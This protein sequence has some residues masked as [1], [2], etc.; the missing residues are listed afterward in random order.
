MFFFMVLPSGSVGA[1]RQNHLNL[2]EAKDT[3]SA[4]GALRQNPQT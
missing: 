3:R 4:R 2:L 1:Q